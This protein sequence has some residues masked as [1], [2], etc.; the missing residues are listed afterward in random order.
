[1]DK[2][3][4]AMLIIYCFTE[5]LTS[6]IVAGFWETNGVEL[7]GST[8]L[9]RPQNDTADNAQPR[10]PVATMSLTF[11]NWINYTKPDCHPKQTNQTANE[12]FSSTNVTS[13]LQ[14]L[15]S[16]FSEKY[17]INIFITIQYA[18]NFYL[19]SSCL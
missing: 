6:L 2:Y 14:V 5:A 8:C 12:Q 11:L 10:T 16:S 19:I 15:L 17:L 4:P 7:K 3:I 1:M 13:C 18:R 9:D